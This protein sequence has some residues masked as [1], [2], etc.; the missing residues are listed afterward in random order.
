MTLPRPPRGVACTI[1]RGTVTGPRFSVDDSPMPF[2]VAMSSSSSPSSRSVSIAAWLSTT[3]SLRR[4]G[5][6]TGGAGEAFTGRINGRTEAVSPS[7]AGRN[8]GSIPR[9]AMSSSRGS[10]PVFQRGG[11]GWLGIAGSV[12]GSGESAG[13][14][15]PGSRPPRA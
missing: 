7:V 6:G 4:G 9:L 15:D 11:G 10:T 12:L 14:F 3:A 5:E 2:A 8:F 13:K 1:S